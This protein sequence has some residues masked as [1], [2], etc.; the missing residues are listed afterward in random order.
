MALGYRQWVCKQEGRPL[1]KTLKVS[2][3]PLR[4][5]FS[6]GHIECGDYVLL[7]EGEY[8]SP[9]RGEVFVTGEVYQ[10]R[11]PLYVPSDLICLGKCGWYG[12][13]SLF[14]PCPHL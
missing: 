10:T 6:E 2:P 11:R 12:G 1:R 14:V 9:T 5:L 13:G 8:T 7:V 3:M 4:E